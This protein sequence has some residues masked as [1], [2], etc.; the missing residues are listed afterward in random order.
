M[1]MISVYSV[2]SEDA[3]IL[4]NANKYP[5]LKSYKI[6]HLNGWNVVKGPQVLS[7]CILLELK[8]SNCADPQLRV[9]I[10]WK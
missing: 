10:F 9:T 2:L 3:G 7:G 5:K 6:S 4:P 8:N 1:L